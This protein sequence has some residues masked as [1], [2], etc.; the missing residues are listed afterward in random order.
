MKD[1]ML[2]SYFSKNFLK[3]SVQFPRFL[4]VLLAVSLLFGC[5][6][7]EDPVPT[8][9]MQPAPEGQ[10]VIVT[11]L[12]LQTETIRVPVTPVVVIDEDEDIVELD[13][14]LEGDINTLDPQIGFQNNDID[15][16][17]NIFVGLTRYNQ[18][19]STFEPELA[20]SWEVSEDGRTWT[21][22]LRDD[23][24]W[25]RRDAGQSTLLGTTPS[26][27]DPV[28][29]VV[30]DDVVYAIQRACDPRTPTADILILF[31]IEGCESLNRTA[32]VTSEAL[33]QVAVQARHP[34]RDRRLRRPLVL[35]ETLGDPRL[36]RHRVRAAPRPVL[37]PVGAAAQ[38]LRPTEHG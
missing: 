17:E 27:I 32:E 21:F 23:I 33:G 4:L 22:N 36:A 12:V 26:E 10:E 31:I 13:I 2:L 3:D 6:E 38:L 25:V 15:I 28:R 16:I 20:E 30:A 11:R 34:R 14:S 29:P 8:P 18:V 37:R 1:R 24:Y 19:L 35:P 7:P 5:Q 9:T